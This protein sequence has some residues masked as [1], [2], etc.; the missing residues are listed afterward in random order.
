MSD[1]K[2]VYCVRNNCDEIQAIYESE[3]EANQLS[4]YLNSKFLDAQPDIADAIHRTKYRVTGYNLKEFH[5]RKRLFWL[6]VAYFSR[7]SYTRLD[8]PYAIA[9]VE[10]YMLIDHELEDKLNMRDDITHHIYFTV[11]YK[12]TK[13]E[14]ESIAYEKLQRF[15]KEGKVIEK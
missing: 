13:K 12:T 5:R 8:C 4:A 11:P 9:N 3:T 6:V 10:R 2:K 7:V 15:Y 1:D 14:L